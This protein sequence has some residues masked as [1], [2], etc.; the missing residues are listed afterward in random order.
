[1]K[2]SNDKTAGHEQRLV[3]FEIDGR[4]YA[5]D[6]YRIQE[7]IYSKEV[8]PVPKAQHYILGVI[9]LRGQI[10][11]V[12]SLRKRL[13]L[14]EAKSGSEPK[15]DDAKS[16]HILIVRI[17]NRLAGLLVDSVREVVRLGPGEIH[18]PDGLFAGEDCRY[19]QGMSRVKERMVLILDLDRLLS[20]QDLESVQ[21]A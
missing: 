13:S 4:A 6:I 3:Q 5:I 16:T 17:S 8:T 10:V 7:I 20:V 18:P 19:L 2:Y 21:A 14:V 9:D 15:G 12:L 1:M 11:P